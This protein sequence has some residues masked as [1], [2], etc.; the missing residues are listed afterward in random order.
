MQI[1]D[2]ILGP[3]ERHHSVFVDHNNQYDLRE[4][5]E[6]EQAS[7]QLTPADQKKFGMAFTK[8]PKVIQIACSNPDGGLHALLLQATGQ[9]GHEAN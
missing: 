9:L 1:P 6:L 5:R 8:F 2:Q 7:L 3:Y 4:A